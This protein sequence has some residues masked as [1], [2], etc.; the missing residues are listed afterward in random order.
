MTIASYFRHHPVICTEQSDRYNL[1]NSDF[2]ELA[3]SI[4]ELQYQ[5]R[6]KI[7]VMLLSAVQDA[8][9]EYANAHSPSMEWALEELQ[10]LTTLFVDS[11]DNI[12]DI[13]FIPSLLIAKMFI[14]QAIALYYHKPKD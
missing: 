3:N 13:N 11:V 6:G 14:K 7:I 2:L 5:N 8:Y 1:V 10:N 12:K 4:Q 9:S